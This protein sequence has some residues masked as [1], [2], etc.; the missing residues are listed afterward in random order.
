MEFQIKC[1]MGM[2]ISDEL[3]EEI[4]A[5]AATNFGNEDADEVDDD[6]DMM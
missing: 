3:Y 6:T 1:L 5:I 2:L 4:P